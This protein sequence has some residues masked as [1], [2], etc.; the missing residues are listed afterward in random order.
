LY[1]S[2]HPQASPVQ[3]HDKIELFTSSVLMGQY[4]ETDRDRKHYLQPVL[5]IEHKDCVVIWETARSI[6]YIP[7]LLKDPVVFP[8]DREQFINNLKK[9]LNKASSLSSI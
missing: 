4:P 6:N 7:Q 1:A 3:L 5:E 8:G 9:F 2:F